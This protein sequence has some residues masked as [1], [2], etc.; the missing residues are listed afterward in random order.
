M[1]SLTWLPAAATGVEGDTEGVALEA[2]VEDGAEG[3]ALEAP[4]GGVPRTG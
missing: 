2:A 3:V 4:A 1:P